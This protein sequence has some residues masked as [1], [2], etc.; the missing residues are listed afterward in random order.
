MFLLVLHFG[1]SLSYCWEVCAHT[2]KQS[3]VAGIGIE[4]FG[5]NA[6]KFM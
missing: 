3:A 4:V 5:S 2:E 1:D 6:V